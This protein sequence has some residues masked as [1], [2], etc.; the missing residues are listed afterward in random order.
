MLNALAAPAASV[1]PISVA[2]EIPSGGNPCEARKGQEVLS[3]AI[4]QQP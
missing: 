1:P 3:Q 2:I 4:A